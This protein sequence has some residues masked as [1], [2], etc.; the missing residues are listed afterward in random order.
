MLVAELPMLVAAL[1]MLVAALQAVAGGHPVRRVPRDE[2]RTPVFSPDLFGSAI[3]PAPS[4]PGSLA[5][6]VRDTNPFLDS[7]ASST[8]SSSS[9]SPAATDEDLSA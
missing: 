6:I 9:V 2:D 8:G 4:V 3:E 7:N 5:L 1:P